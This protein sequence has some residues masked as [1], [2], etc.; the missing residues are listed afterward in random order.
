MSVSP[1]LSQRG[2]PACHGRHTHR[3]TPRTLR[4]SAGGSQEASLLSKGL[5]KIGPFEEPKVSFV[6]GGR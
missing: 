2:V 5:E 6:E 4:V 1:E 3:L